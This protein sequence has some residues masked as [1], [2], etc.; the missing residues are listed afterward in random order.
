MEDRMSND[1]AAAKAESIDDGRITDE[2]IERER[3]QIGVSQYEHG[4]CFNRLISEDAIRHFAFGFVADENPLWHE[5]DYGRTTRWRGQIAPPLFAT[6]TGINETPRY[7]TPEMKALF[8]GLYRGVGRYNVGTRWKLFKPI[9]SG[10]VIY[11]DTAVD[12][13]QV[14]EQSSFSGGRTVLDRIRHLY[15]NRDGEPVAVRYEHFINA[16]RSGSKKVSKHADIK[17]QV[18]TPEDIAKIDAHYAA[19]Q[20]RGSEP[21]WWEDVSVGDKIVPVVKGPLGTLDVIAGHLGWGLGTTYGAGPLRYNWK[22]RQKLPGFFSEDQYGVPQSMI[23]LHWDQDRAEQLG[24]PAPYDYGQMRSNW[25]THAITNWM[26]DDAWISDLNTEIRGFNFHGDTTLITGEV[27]A[28]RMDGDDCVV[29]LELIGTSQRDVV[30]CKA[31]AT[32]KLPSR[33]HGAIVLPRPAPELCAVGAKIMT[34]SAKRL[35]EGK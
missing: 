8:K 5:P 17:R 9:R 13:V 35:R 34:E 33:K 29:D 27:V 19:E 23:R 24:L 15:I 16:E 10:D 14:K 21:R 2:D 30:T 7:T 32:V 12:D 4:M 18:Y 1:A 31:Q 26:G 20:I 11:H 6:T 28:K 3:R 22:T 25:L